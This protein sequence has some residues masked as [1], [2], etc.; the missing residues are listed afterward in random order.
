[1]Q[2]AEQL[3][4]HAGH[5][6]RGLAQPLAV[7]VLADGQQDL[8]HRALDPRLIDDVSVLAALVIDFRIEVPLTRSPIENDGHGS[9]VSV[10]NRESS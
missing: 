9:Y 8:A 2:A 5:A 3:G 6:G 4:I 7:G 10:A 1:M